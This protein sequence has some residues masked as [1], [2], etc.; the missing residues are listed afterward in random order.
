M[1]SRLGPALQAAGAPQPERM[2]WLSLMGH[3]TA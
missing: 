2:E 1:T 3:R